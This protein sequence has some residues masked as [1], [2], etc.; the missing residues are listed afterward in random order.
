MHATN[1]SRQ[2]C[3]QL[4]SIT[5]DLDILALIQKDVIA[6][7]REYLFEAP[8]FLMR[9]LHEKD[10]HDKPMAFLAYNIVSG[11]SS[12]LFFVC[13]SFHSPFAGENRL[14]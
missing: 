14:C 5:D 2:E 4:A 12:L 1:Q 8:A 7:R 11:S 6:K 13:T 10:P 9:C 3:Q